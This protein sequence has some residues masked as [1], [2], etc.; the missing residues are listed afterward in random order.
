MWAWVVI[1]LGQLPKTAVAGW[2]GKHIFSFV[3]RLLNCFPEWLNHFTFSSAMDEWSGIFTSLPGFVVL[4]IFYIRRSEGVVISHCGFNLH[5]PDD[6]EHR[7]MCFFAISISSS[8]KCLF[9]VPIFV[10]FINGFFPVE[11]WEFF[12]YSREVSYLDMWF[13]NIFPQYGNLYFHPFNR[14]L[15]RSEVFNFDEVWFI[16]FLFYVA[17]FWCHLEEFFI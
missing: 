4:T 15:C 8:V 6:V 9:L 3:K 2:Y 16:H 1:S 11:F 14:V 17:G 12:I 13:I 5:F 7:F 10:H